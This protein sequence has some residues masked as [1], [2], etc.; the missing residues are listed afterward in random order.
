MDIDG[1]VDITEKYNDDFANQSNQYENNNVNDELDNINESNYG[2]PDGLVV[3]NHNNQNNYLT[4]NEDLEDNQENENIDMDNI[5]DIE[6]NEDIE[7]NDDI[8]NNNSIQYGGSTFSNY[9]SNLSYLSELNL[10]KDITTDELVGNIVWDIN[11]S[12]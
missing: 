4:N 1:I 5:G 6:L 8:E 9:L 2:F 11:P 10:Y 12:L 7:L 3:L